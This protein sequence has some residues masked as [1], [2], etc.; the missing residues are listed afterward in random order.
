VTPLDPVVLHE[1]PLI[2]KII[3]DETWFEGERRG[4]WVSSD[5]PVVRENVCR[6]IFRV[7]E[8]L[9]KM[10]MAQ[11]NAESQPVTWSDHDSK[12]NQAA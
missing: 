5:D 3:R 2:K 7:G 12:D 1:I 8:E 4:C 9:R 11:I 10:F 6:V